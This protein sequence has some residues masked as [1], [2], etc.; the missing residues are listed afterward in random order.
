LRPGPAMLDGAPQPAA[1][2]G[3][4]PVPGVWPVPAPVRPGDRVVCPGEGTEIA[5][6]LVK[7]QANA[8]ILPSSN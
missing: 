4:D 7:V 3:P 8:G 5:N 6:K 2:K 1:A